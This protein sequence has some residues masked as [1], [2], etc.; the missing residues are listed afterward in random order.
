[1]MDLG[2][3]QYYLGMRV[4]RDR[5]NRTIRLGQRAYA[6]KILRDY[7]MADCKPAA[8][9]MDTN[10]NLNPAENGYEALSE[11]KLWYQGAVGALMYL[12]LGTRPELAFA[13]S[14]VSRYSANP[15]DAHV[16]TIKRIFRYLKGILNYELI[17]RGS[18]SPLVGYTNI[19]WAGDKGTRRS[20]SGYTFN[21]GSGAISW[22]SKRQAT[23]ALLT[24]EAEY[25][26]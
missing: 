23:V 25:V 18:T 6:E 11:I 1:M 24:C 13:I 7:G 15:T 10:L 19:D 3:C 21:I 12:M 9:P 17:F 20:T 4:T 2:P 14:V 22:S 5:V 16:S 8:T 26:A